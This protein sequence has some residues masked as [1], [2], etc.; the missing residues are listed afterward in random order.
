MMPKYDSL[1]KTKRD[2]EIRRYVKK[3]P[4]YSHQEIANKFGISRSNVT[5][6]LNSQHIPHNDLSP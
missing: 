1:R 4:A 6:I 2:N 5:R 3:H